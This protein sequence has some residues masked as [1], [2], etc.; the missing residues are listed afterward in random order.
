MNRL[1]HLTRHP[2]LGQLAIRQAGMTLLEYGIIGVSVVAVCIVAFISLG[3]DLNDWFAGIKQDMQTQVQTTNTKQA[4][5]AAA[6]L[7]DQAARANS[8]IPN[9]PMTGIQASPSNPNS[10]CS[11]TWCINAPGLTGDSIYTAGSNGNQMVELTQSAAGIYEQIA[12]ILEKQN[13]DPSLVALLTSLANQGHSL[14]NNQAMFLAPGVS[15]ADMKSGMSN[16]QSGLATFK[17]LTQQ[18]NSVLNQLPADTRGI[19]VD[20]SNVIIGVGDSYSFNI[21]SGSTAEIGWSYTSSNIQLVHSNSNTICAN[22][23]DTGSCIQ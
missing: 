21:P 2:S 9:V 5:W 7:A 13:A 12:A 15:Y 8:D 11:G 23:G 18:L 4:A 22:G 6:K 17:Q 19:L 1:P 14:A 10:L 20:A 3:G 16:T